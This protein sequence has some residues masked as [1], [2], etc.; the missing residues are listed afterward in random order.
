MN[1]Q[2]NMLYD[3]DL[4]AIND[5]IAMIGGM[6]NSLPSFN[7]LYLAVY[8]VFTF[9]GFWGPLMAGLGSFRIYSQMIQ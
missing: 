3:L 7:L 2:I 6:V 1:Y 8:F 4:N 5:V 9:A